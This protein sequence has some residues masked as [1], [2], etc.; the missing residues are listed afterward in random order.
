MP[1][2]L[3]LPYLARAGVLTRCRLAER[4]VGLAAQEAAVAQQ[5][6]RIDGLHT[7]LQTELAAARDGLRSLEA[8][9]PEHALPADL[10]TRVAEWTRTARHLRYKTEDYRDRLRSMQAGA[11]AGAGADSG[12]AV[13]TGAETGSGAGAGTG[14]GVGAGG[15]TVPELMRQEHEV[16]ALKEH[17]LGLEA[18]VRGFQGLPP[19]K[20]LA[21]LE[22]ER[23][24]AELEALEAALEQ[25][26]DGMVH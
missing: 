21:R 20:D 6:G 12:V 1:A 25:L 9:R 4:L 13:G 2:G 23:V 18:Q 22:V 14:T 24:Q 16:L 7:R 11:G 10:A 19:E 8:G 17:V 15:L 26:Y 5:T 3:A